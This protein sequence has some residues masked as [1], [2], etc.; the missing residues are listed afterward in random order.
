MTHVFIGIAWLVALAWLYKCA[1][2]AIG[3]PKVP[4]LALPEADLSTQIQPKLVVIVPA[5]NEQDDIADCIE[6]LLH[7]DYANLHIIAV[8]DRSTD[9]TGVIMDQIAAKARGKLHV[10]HI[11]ELPP[12]WLG[13]THALAMAAR[14]A[15]TR[16]DPNYLLFT[17]GDVV[18]EPTI[19][20]RALAYATVSGADH[21]VVMPTTIAKT[22]REAAIL[23]FLQVFSLWAVRPWRVPDPRAKRDAMGIGAFNLIR[24]AAYRQIGGFEAAPMEVLEDLF[25]GRR[26]KWASLKQGVAVAPGMVRVHW[27]AG[28]RGLVYGMTKNTF[29]VFRF[30][31]MLLLVAA[32]GI[33]LDTVGPA[34]FLAF[35]VT[36]IAGAVSLA[37]VFGTYTISG[38]ATRISPVYAL[39]FPFAGAAIVYAMLRS[40][41]VTVRNRGVLWRGTFY[42]IEELRRGMARRTN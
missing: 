28:A 35:P 14:E 12:G 20:R 34:V 23:S 9:A 3:F 6:S 38:R 13:K 10:L 22:W 8:D 26:I 39:C 5:R 15:M 11:N 17:D 42:S 37:A 25:L 29:A 7:Q 31:P 32:L 4:N 41:F 21:F 33:V 40:M 36:R 2:T 1:E 18:F 16:F 27:A 30:N 24:V 19:L